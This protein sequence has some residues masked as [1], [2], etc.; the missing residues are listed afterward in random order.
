[1][2][3]AVLIILIL[4]IDAGVPQ[5]SPKTSPAHPA[6]RGCSTLPESITC[7]SRQTQ[8]CKCRNGV[9]YCT[10]RPVW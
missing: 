6:P 1:M 4:F 7:P 9:W 3:R 10:C 8:R 2:I 5:K